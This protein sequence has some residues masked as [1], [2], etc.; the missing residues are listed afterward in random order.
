MR[1]PWGRAETLHWG[2]ERPQKQP[3]GIK[4]TSYS[5]ESFANLVSSLSQGVKVLDGFLSEVYDLRLKGDLDKAHPKYPRTL[6][7]SFV[8]S[9]P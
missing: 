5:Q 2:G 6:P 9:I 4:K 8:L 7:A 3:K 1:A